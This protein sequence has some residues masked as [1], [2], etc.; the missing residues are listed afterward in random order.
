M[1]AKVYHFIPLIDRIQKIVTPVA[2][3]T[4]RSDG[5]LRQK[6]QEVNRMNY[7]KIPTYIEFGLA[8]LEEGKVI[9]Q[10]EICDFMSLREALIEELARTSWEN[11]VY[12]EPETWYNDY[13]DH[14]SL[15]VEKK[16]I[17][18]SIAANTSIS[19]EKVH[20]L[21]DE[22]WKDWADKVRIINH[23]LGV[24]V[25]PKMWSKTKATQHFIQSRPEDQYH[26]FVFGDNPS[27]IEM[28]IGLT[29]STFVSTKERASIEVLETLTKLDII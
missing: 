8:Y 6:Y 20:S 5:W 25:I 17:Q 10:E 27:D 9:I 29:N 18:L 12:F 21:T 14:G 19:V 7:L 11:D 22:A 28:T 2:F 3:V 23:H 15:W 24:D 13:P 26:W 4:G 1:L 16:H